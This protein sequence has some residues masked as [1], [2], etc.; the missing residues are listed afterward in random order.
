MTT[1]LADLPP[2]MTDP[3]AGTQGAFRTLLD[4]MAR[5]GRVRALPDA[6]TAGLQAAADDRRDRPGPGLAA[7]LLTLLDAET[8]VQLLGTLDS[9]GTR[10]WLRFHTGVR[11]A[12]VG[13]TAAFTVV[14]ADDLSPA[15]WQAIDL[16]TDEAPQRG[17]TLI[18]E[19]PHLQA[20]SAAPVRAAAADGCAATV[21]TLR[22]PGIADAHHLA[23]GG[24]PDA[25]WAHR[26]QLRPLYPRGFELVLVRG[27]HLAA[28]PRTTR[29]TIDA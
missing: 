12:T 7:L 22:G 21:L 5:P 23:V 3:V 29:L 18:V 10:A 26:Q 11:A 9:P 28:I 15:A 6:A 24:L 19:V 14:R 2:G 20:L 13:G 8:Q 1:A 16:G 17:G 4:A 27:H 25:F